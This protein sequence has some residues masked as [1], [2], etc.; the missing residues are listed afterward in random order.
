M[1]QYDL[2]SDCSPQMQ[3]VLS[4]HTTDC[5]PSSE[6][7]ETLQ[8][9][10]DLFFPLL[11][12]L[13][14]KETVPLLLFYFIFHVAFNGS[15][16]SRL[17]K[18]SS[19]FSISFQLI[20]WL[21]IISTCYTSLNVKMFLGKL[22]KAHSCFV[23]EAFVS[24]YMCFIRFNLQFWSD[25]SNSVVKIQCWSIPITPQRM[26]SCS[27]T[28]LSNCHLIPVERCQTASYASEL[29]SQGLVSLC[30]ALAEL[31]THF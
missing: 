21:N 8:C 7:K 25:F 11:L 29:H 5:A 23:K 6:H 27:I 9:S 3:I 22:N 4:K 1:I 12:L 15:A 18:C 28:Q 10:S 19:I 16:F 30:R 24:N 31:N 14:P 17:I 13:D 2:S 26:H 20:K